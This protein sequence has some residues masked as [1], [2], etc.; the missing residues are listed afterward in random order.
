MNTTVRLSKSKYMAGRQCEKRLW[1]EVHRPD[2]IEWDDAQTARLAKGTAFGELARELLGPGVLVDFGPDMPA[3]VARTSELIQ[4]SKPPRHVF[5]ATMSHR[6]VLVRVDALRRKGAAFEVIEV[7]SSGSVKEPYLD[8]C[9]V[10]TWVARGAGIDTRRTWVALADSQFVYVEEGNYEGLLKLQDVS[11]EVEA[12][13]AD[14]PRLVRRF[15]EVLREDEPDICTGPHCRKPYECPFIAHCQAQEEPGPDYPLELWARSPA[16]VQRLA[17]AGFEDLRDVPLDLVPKGKYQ[18]MLKGIRRGKAIVAP[19]LRRQLAELP[20][21]RRYLD[22]EAIDFIVP[23]WLGTR[24]FEHIPFQWSCHVEKAAGDVVARGFL[25]ISGDDPRRQLAV[26]LIKTCGK[27]GP[28]LVYGRYESQCLASLSRHLPDLAGALD[29]IGARLVDLLPLMQ[30]H[31]YH[32]EMGKSW[33]LKSVLPTVVSSLD[34]GDLGDVADGV[35]AQDAYIEAIDA[36]TTPARRRELKSALKR[37][38]ERDTWGLVEMV[39]VL[40]KR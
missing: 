28:I 30:N 17:D 16:L 27:R 35:A 7:K 5:E 21:P 22:F 2:L 32:P 8:D 18:R 29:A 13:Q 31:Y 24:P 3:A 23:R 12:R 1:L 37:Y 34:Y 25:D 19:E 15:Q 4:K 39:R 33:S 6:N 38:C 36:A 40:S 9:A 10:Q 26:A 14:V 11:A 20:Y